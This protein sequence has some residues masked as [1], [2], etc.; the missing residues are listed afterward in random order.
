MIQVIDTFLCQVTNPTPSPDPFSRGMQPQHQ[1]QTEQTLSNQISSRIQPLP[2]ES[3]NAEAPAGQL[4]FPSHGVP[5]SGERHSNEVAQGQGAQLSHT[6]EENQSHNIDSIKTLPESDNELSVPEVVRAPGNSSFQE[7]N[8]IHDENSFAPGSSNE[9]V[10]TA[11]VGDAA[12]IF[13]HVTRT[14]ESYAR[15]PKVPRR[16]SNAS[17]N[18]TP[19]QA[20]FNR[21]SQNVGSARPVL[22][23]RQAHVRKEQDF[24]PSFKSEVDGSPKNQ[25]DEGQEYEQ[26]NPAPQSQD[27]AHESPST[28]IT[29]ETNTDR[30]ASNHA[31][32]QRFSERS[33]SIFHTASRREEPQRV[34]K[35]EAQSV[36]QPQ[37]FP[38]G[39]PQ[40]FVARG[41]SSSQ[42]GLIPSSQ[43]QSAITG[44]QR[45][46]RP[47]SFME[48]SQDQPN[49]L[50]PEVLQRA[51]SI[52]SIPNARYP[53]RPPSPVSP[54]RSMTRDVSEQREQTLPTHYDT[55]HDFFPSDNG[56][57]SMRRPRSL[58][59]PFQ[60]P[61]LLEHP[62]FRH[63]SPQVRGADILTEYHS[64]QTPREEMRL[65]RQQT[66]EYQL[67]GVGPPSIPRTDTKSRSRRSSR[68][69][70]FFR[71]LGNSGKVEGP[72]KNSPEAQFVES[73]ARDVVASRKKSNRNS[74][75]RTLT[76]RS[77]SDRDQTLASVEKPAV[78]SQN[79][80]PQQPISLSPRKIEEDFVSSGT[81]SKTP[82]KLQRASTSGPP[83]KSV[84]K[85]KRFSAIGVSS[86]Q[87]ENRGFH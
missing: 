53:D 44:S 34:P 58:S 51:P 25:E 50:R 65:P 49:Q 10:Q 74:V 87:S 47:F 43:L 45:A 56:K 39:R 26:A 38:Q 59:R 42:T 41:G 3:S 84:G 61:N 80:V 67:E 24:D 73:P 1:P 32:K 79:I 18:Q 6:Y 83:E 40:E 16:S 57:G 35:T 60:D 13:L 21:S 55:S 54:Q 64:A 9:Q 33:D 62:A 36:T 70:V 12:P 46:T 14:A 7:N 29:H 86:S 77:G 11:T 5:V 8:A 76:G 30:Q 31:S 22:L 85:K 28:D 15:S 4:Y 17:S 23:D 72:S 37:A 19:T 82:N 81:S 52:D 68:S 78:Q 48:Y 63:E 69:S 71:N 27:P 75:F 2:Q 66:T 20:D